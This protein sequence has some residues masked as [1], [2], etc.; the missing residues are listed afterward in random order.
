MNPYIKWSVM[1]C[2]QPNWQFEREKLY[3]NNIY[4]SKTVIIDMIVEHI[5][6][7]WCL[8][9]STLPLISASAYPEERKDI[10]NIQW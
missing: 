1:T 6:H 10:I 7:Y 3:K 4:S 9:C 5:Q 8:Y 2:C